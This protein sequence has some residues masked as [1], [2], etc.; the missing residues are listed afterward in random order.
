MPMASVSPMSPLNNPNAYTGGN[1]LTNAMGQAGMQQM[2][3]LQQGAQQGDYGVKQAKIGAGAQLGS[4]QAAA[5]A[6]KYGA[7]TQLQG[8]QAQLAQ[9]Q[10][11]YNQIFPMIQGAYGQL[12]GGG[13]GM[14]NGSGYGIAGGQGGGAVG[15]Y[16][17][18]T[19]AP[20]VPAPPSGGGLPPA[21]SQQ[22]QNANV[23]LNNAQN[24]AQAGG[25]SKRQTQQLAGSG[26]GATSPLA[27]ALQAQVFGGALAANTA[28]ATTAR[29]QAAQLNAQQALGAYQADQGARAS[30]Y[31]SQVGAQASQYGSRLN[32]QAALAQ[33]QAQKQNALLAALS[34]FAGS[35]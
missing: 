27:K 23:N 3:N 21:I 11:R 1:P 5:E 31:G 18:G 30:E 26:L 2:Y 35:V 8:L 6:S 10:G 20:A 33:V 24:W 15:N 22:Q 12:S 4:A 19:A 14:N 13:G 29:Q 28:G 7:N 25:E 34:N 9:S 32:Y 16:G 17:Y